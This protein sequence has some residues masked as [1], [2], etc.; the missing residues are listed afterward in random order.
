MPVWL[1][2]TADKEPDVTLTS[3]GAF[4]VL[5]P[6]IG[7]PTTHVVGYSRDGMEGRVSSGFTKLDAE[8]GQVITKSGRVYRLEGSPGLHPDAAYVWQQWQ[9]TWEVSVLRDLS[10]ELFETITRATRPA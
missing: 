10:V 4:E 6:R 9:S 1:P 7:R 2:T 5:I 3:W 8:R